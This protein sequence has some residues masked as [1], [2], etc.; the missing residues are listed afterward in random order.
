M[1]NEM[2]DLAQ[3]R[4]SLTD[5]QAQLDELYLLLELSIILTGLGGLVTASASRFSLR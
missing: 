2:K 3:L 4:V 1:Q 5:P